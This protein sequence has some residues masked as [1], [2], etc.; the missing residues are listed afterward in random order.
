MAQEQMCATSSMS[1]DPTRDDGQLRIINLRFGRNFAVVW[2]RL[3][4]EGEFD[5]AAAGEL[6]L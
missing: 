5:A 1:P 2:T 3:I 4:M 6:Y